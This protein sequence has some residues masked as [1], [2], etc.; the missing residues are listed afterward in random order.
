MSVQHL[1]IEDA[2]TWWQAGDPQIF[3]ADVL[4]SSNSASMSVGFARYDKGAANEWVVTYDQA[5][6]VT[7]G[8]L[9]VHTADRVITAK[10]GEA[11]FL[12]EGTKV[13]YEGEQDGT[14]VVYVTFPHWWDVHRDSEHAHL[15]AEFRPVRGVTRLM[16]ALARPPAL[17]G[18]PAAQP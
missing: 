17:S 1:T 13:E 11:I 8:L 6:I 10:V 18:A 4:D 7:K 14:E 3:I 2:T 12:T 9:T 16:P 15:L 5:L